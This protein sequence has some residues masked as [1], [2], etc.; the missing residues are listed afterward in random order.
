MAAL[1]L[2]PIKKKYST[3]FLR[4]L[5]LATKKKNLSSTLLSCHGCYRARPAPLNISP[6]FGMIRKKKIRP[7]MKQQLFRPAVC[8][9]A[10]HP[11]ALQS[12]SHNDAS[13]HKWIE[14][15]HFCTRFDTHGGMT[16]SQITGEIS[17]ENRQR[18]GST[19]FKTLKTSL[20]N[21]LTDKKSQ[22]CYLKRAPHAK[23]FVFLFFLP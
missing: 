8:N 10:L 23:Y 15:I 11:C 7:K 4:S 2:S 13:M 21:N 3:K 20:K 19:K 6:I 1:L 22:K 14:T 12:T 9:T 17:S 18:N 5:S 16:S